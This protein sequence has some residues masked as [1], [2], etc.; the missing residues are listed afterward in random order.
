MVSGENSGV[1][2]DGGAK[3]I[4]S[5]DRAEVVVYRPCVAGPAA[6]A[7]FVCLIMGRC[8]PL[9]RVSGVSGMIVRSGELWCFE[10]SVSLCSMGWCAA[11]W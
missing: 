6:K 8:V 5:W 3:L 10:A 9:L 4:T 1:T 7:S 11:V 2:V